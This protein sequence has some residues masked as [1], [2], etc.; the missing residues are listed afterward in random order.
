MAVEVGAGGVLTGANLYD[1]DPTQAER[2]D[3][4]VIGPVDEIAG[5]TPSPEELEPTMRSVD[6]VSR[7]PIAVIDP[8]PHDKICGYN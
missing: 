2:S 6:V 5:D 7:G 3:G 8:L 4:T 1:A